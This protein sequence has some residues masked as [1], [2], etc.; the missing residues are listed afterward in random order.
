[1]D[2]WK[3]VPGSLNPADCS[4]RGFPANRLNNCSW[5]H[6]PSFLREEFIPDFEVSTISPATNPNSQFQAGEISYSEKTCLKESEEEEEEEKEEEEREKRH[7]APTMPREIV[8]A[9]LQANYKPQVI[10][11]N[12]FSNYKKLIRVFAYILRL[13]QSHYV[14]RQTTKL[15]HPEEYLAAE[16]RIFIL[17]QKESFAEELKHLRKNQN[18]SRCSRIIKFNPFL[19]SDNPLRSTGR[20]SRMKE[21]PFEVKHPII[22]DN[23]HPAVCLLLQHIYQIHLHKGVEYL[24]SVIQQDYAV[25]RLRSALRKLESERLFCRR[26]RAKCL[27][28]LMPD[29]PT[30]RLAYRK[31]AFTNTGLDCFGPLHVTVRRATEKRCIIIFTCLTTRAIH[32]EVLHSLNTSSR[33][34]AIVRF[35]AR[36]RST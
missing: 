1:M 13:L 25:L 5:I 30:E 23:P 21:A 27:Q 7:S 10:P 32:L 33:M 9:A 8:T 6:G 17:S 18:L 29:L 36:Q 12:R 3:F 28:P 34:M 14:F 16:K 20:T 4:T 15:L 35:V 26:R 24:R 2:Q 11:W 22:L 19:G 31:P